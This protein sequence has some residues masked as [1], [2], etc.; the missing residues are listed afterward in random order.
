MRHI[1]LFISILF[2][3]NSFAQVNDYNLRIGST[4]SQDSVY[5]LLTDT[6]GAFRGRGQFKSIPQLAAK[7]IPF[8]GVS[9]IS[10]GDKGDITVSGGGLTWNIDANAVGSSE[11]ATDGVGSTEIES[12]GVSADEYPWN[13]RYVVDE[14]GRI[15]DAVILGDLQADLTEDR[16]FNI[17]NSAGLVPNSTTDSVET[18]NVKYILLNGLSGGL[19]TKIEFLKEGILYFDKRNDGGDLGDYYMKFTGFDTLNDVTFNFENTSNQTINGELRNLESFGIGWNIGHFGTQENADRSMAGLFFE[20]NWDNP[21]EDQLWDE[22]Q[23]RHTDTSGTVRRPM[24]M[25][26][27]NSD[28]HDWGLSW[29]FPTINFRP[30][31]TTAPYLQLLYGIDDFKTQIKWFNPYTGTGMQMIMDE[32]INRFTWSNNGLVDPMLNIDGFDTVSIVNAK[33]GIGTETP[34][35]TLYTRGDVGQY[36]T[37]VTSVGT[38]IGSSLYL[39]D[40]GF[41]N[42]GFYNK[43]PGISAVFNAVQGV[44]SDLA[45]YAY[46]GGRTERMR[47][48]E[49]GRLG[50]LTTDPQQALHVAGGMRLTGSDGTAT[51]IMGRDADGDISVLGVGTNLS[52]TGGT[53]NA[54]TQSDAD[55]YESGDTPPNAITDEMYHT[56][57]VH[58]GDATMAQ[59]G[60]LNITGRVEQN[61]QTTSTAFG[62]D[63]GAAIAS[64]I[65]SS[66]FGYHTGTNTTAAGN[67]GFGA[68]ALEDNT[69]GLQNTAFGNQALTNNIDGDNNI[70]I[71]NLALLTNTTGNNNTAIGKEAGRTG[72]GSGNIFLGYLSGFS[73]TG[74]NKLYISNSATDELIRGD[75][76]S[77][78]VHI[79]GSL[80]LRDEFI[81]AN[82]S[83]GT[84]GQ[85]LSSTETGTDWIDVAAGSAHTI[86]DDG[87]DET[88]RAAL[89]FVSTST[90]DM[91]GTDDAGNNETEIAASVVA[92]S[93]GDNE[94]G[95]GIDVTQLADGTVTSSEF[96]FI[97]TLTSNAQTQINTKAPIDAPVF[98]SSVTLPTEAAP[99]P[100]ADGHIEYATDQDR[101]VAGGAGGLTGSF[102]RVLAVGH[103][104]ESKTNSTASDQD[105]TSVF[106]IP[107][108]YLIENKVLR[109]TL[110]WQI[111]TGTST[112]TVIN[113]LKVGS[114]KVYISG[115]LNVTNG[116]TARGTS[117]VFYVYGTAA[118]G[119]SANVETFPVSLIVGVNDA[120]NNSVAQPIALATNG[121]LAITPGITYSGTGSTETYVLRTYT[122]EELN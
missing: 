21:D 17:Y 110:N 51:T 63:A 59:D 40:E 87:S 116:L 13:T 8:L 15:I 29:T 113:Y 47:L 95:T 121:T 80:K 100:T 46:N 3:V 33:V 107:A 79:K 57:D 27:S 119:A 89:N 38:P 64:S 83:A 73:E 50:I 74:S 53:L 55:F 93:I 14:D 44:A 71:G 34:Y 82:G 117:Q 28:T 88:Q 97:N 103:P 68:T 112:V 43:T 36:S 32:P 41:N 106:T 75:M 45:F 81:D 91:V 52:I 5:V 31:D 60:K 16:V 67:N 78:S 42:S 20:Y 94:L 65:S 35:S 6:I 77:D 109:V 84:S 12:T 118:A 105:Y 66:F 114:T 85:V 37:Y 102:P 23:F 115:A 11:I 122:I 98:T 92:G 2:C 99:A 69:T 76:S 111:A 9:G 49:N 26:L 101:Y 10:D 86:R 108:N 7:L 56:G 96:Q 25:L 72:N 90:I 4:K 48:T 22:I 62:D 18:T 1:I 30:P 39:G 58:I 54:A 61:W 120:S 70:G 19:D 104:A 24:D